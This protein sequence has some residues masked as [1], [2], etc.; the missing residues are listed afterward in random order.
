MLLQRQQRPE[1]GQDEVIEPFVDAEKGAE[2]LG[3]TRRRLLEMA[4][5]KEIPGHAIGRGKRKTWR[6][7]LSEL[8]DTVVGKTVASTFKRDMIEIGSP[9]Q[10]NR[11]N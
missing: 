1:I 5:A 8:A 7:R 4:R 2:F 6:F 9:R 11:R 3:I 10:P